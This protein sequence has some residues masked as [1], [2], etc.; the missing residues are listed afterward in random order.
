MLLHNLFEKTRALFSFNSAI[1]GNKI[2][3]QVSA[4]NKQVFISCTYFAD[5]VNL[6][7]EFVL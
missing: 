3:S 2:R 6:I 4:G 1:D 7:G 5:I